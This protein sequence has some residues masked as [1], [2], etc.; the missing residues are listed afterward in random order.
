[1][2]DWNQKQQ[3]LLAGRR[4]PGRS[5]AQSRDLPLSSR[6]TVG[7]MRDRRGAF[8][9]NSADTAKPMVVDPGSPL[10]SGRDDDLV[11]GCAGII[12][13]AEPK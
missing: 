3:T 5:G 6:A 4:H 12:D 1:M 2:A 9:P 8:P 13:L 11:T 7:W 10:R